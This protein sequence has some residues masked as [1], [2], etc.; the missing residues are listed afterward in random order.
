MFSAHSIFKDWIC[1]T[2][3]DL[4]H[5]TTRALFRR[6]GYELILS[7]EVPGITCS[8]HKMYSEKTFGWKIHAKSYV[9]LWFYGLQWANSR[10]VLG[11]KLQEEKHLG[12]LGVDGR[13]K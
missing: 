11:E 5:D 6:K 12:D 8:S 2:T 9:H 3:E 1:I 13:V 4:K 7:P 10:K